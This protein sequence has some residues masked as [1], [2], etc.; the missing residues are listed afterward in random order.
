M[1]GP[2]GLDVG[3]IPYNQTHGMDAL[4]PML[5][6]LGALG[7]K[8]ES[9]RQA[10]MSDALQRRELAGREYKD[11]SDQRRQLV[12][13]FSKAYVE[14]AQKALAVYTPQFAEH[15]MDIG[16]PGM[17]QA[18][19]AADQLVRQGA[20]PADQA[21]GDNAT[22]ADSPPGNPITVAPTVQAAT[23]RPGEDASAFM[24]RSRAAQPAAPQEAQTYEGKA[25]KPYETKVEGDVKGA[26]RP[27]KAPPM[28]TPGLDDWRRMESYKV[29]TEP[30]E[31]VQPPDEVK[32]ALKSPTITPEEFKAQGSP[33]PV[34]DE[35]KKAPVS[36]SGGPVITDRATGRTIATMSPP[37][38][39]D[40]D[41]ARM[42]AEATALA[43]N[44]PD[45]NLR[46]FAKAYLTE[47]ITKGSIRDHQQLQWAEAYIA[48]L[49]RAELNA[50]AAKHRGGGRDPGLAW[51]TGF[52]ATEKAM[53]DFHVKDDEEVVQQAEKAKALLAT[54]NLNGLKA[55][56]YAIARMND[57]KGIVTEGDFKNAGVATLWEK[58]KDFFLGNGPE[59]TLTPSEVAR[60]GELMQTL[61]D[62]ATRRL[63]EKMHNVSSMS[64]DMPDPNMVLGHQSSMKKQFG[65]YGY[66]TRGTQSAPPTKD[67]PDRPPLQ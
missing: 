49:S 25:L 39:H 38:P 32:A 48:G 1:S 30:D 63:H 45:T 36:T 5:G 37:E 64:A 52:Q 55:V 46:D 15:G 59:P 13:D 65:K 31:S 12:S 33:A 66:G 58:T 40:R 29:P 2:W 60:M 50:E 27:R 43:D 20:A 8:N 54:G 24:A 51:N 22:A 10:N 42:L 11:V 57:P 44:F 6:A 23:R 61:S 7:Q 16:T 62:A 35:W 4:G 18:L 19:L 3:V 9:A 21:P 56:Q 41:Q 34:T 67:F 17:A 26:L 53:D 14:D 47:G 28:P